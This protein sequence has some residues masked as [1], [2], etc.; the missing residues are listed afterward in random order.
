M[1]P[2]VET[3]AVLGVHEMSE[4]VVMFAMFGIALAAIIVP[5]SSIAILKALRPGGKTE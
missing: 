2:T 4:S 3:V 1:V 5:I